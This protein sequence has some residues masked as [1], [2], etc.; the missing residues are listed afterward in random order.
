MELVDLRFTWAVHIV[1]RQQ[2]TSSRRSQSDGVG[3]LWQCTAPPKRVRLVSSVR[4]VAGILYME[5]AD[6]RYVGRTAQVT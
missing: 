3:E 5:L 4:A 6:L 2:A 1:G